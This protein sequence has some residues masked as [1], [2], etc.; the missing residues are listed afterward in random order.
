MANVEL[1]NKL[2]EFHKDLKSIQ[3][4]QSE[5]Y[6][7]ILVIFGEYEKFCQDVIKELRDEQ[8]R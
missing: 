8:K 7:D 5:I 3:E 1:L 4:K 6:K 2:D